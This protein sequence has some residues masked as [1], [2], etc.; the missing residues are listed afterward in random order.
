MARATWVGE[1]FYEAAARIAHEGLRRDGSLFSS[2]TAIWAAATV[3]ELEPAL[4][5]VDTS[6]SSF[7]EKLQEQLIDL[8][9]AAIQLGAEL[10]YVELL[11]EADTGAAKK[12]EHIDGVLALLPDPVKVPRELDDALRYG[13]AT[14]GQGGRNRRDAFL[15][16][17]A[18]L[19]T[20]WKHV[21]PN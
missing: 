15:R 17:L 13:I 10:L 21:D 16:F 5:V 1:S 12:R 9:P 7:G 11:G 14:Y 20:E 8:S 4:S 6:D 19:V 2:G 3:T 18:S